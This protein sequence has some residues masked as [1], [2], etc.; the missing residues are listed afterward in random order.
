MIYIVKNKLF[1]YNENLK[2]NNFLFHM[3]GDRCLQ[4]FVRHNVQLIS[5]RKKERE[6]GEEEEVQI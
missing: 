1:D 2:I 4:L 6:E 3:C 5:R